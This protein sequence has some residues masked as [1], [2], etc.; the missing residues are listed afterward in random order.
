M[1]QQARGWRLVADAQRLV[2]DRFLDY[3]CLYWWESPAVAFD[4]RRGY[5]VQYNTAL[6]QVLRKL[7]FDCVLVYS[8]RVRL[9]DDPGW[10]MGHV[11]VQVALDGQTRDVCASSTSLTAG[12][13]RFEPLT[14][15]RRFSTGPRFLTV[16]GTAMA[17]VAAL[18]RARLT[19]TVVPRWL[20]HPFGA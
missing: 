1:Q 2:H 3:S 13:P 4:R 8:T 15:V 7:G 6:F 14:P 5:C 11:W 16:A 17:V 12:S 19:R 10:R 18:L 20:H 9:V